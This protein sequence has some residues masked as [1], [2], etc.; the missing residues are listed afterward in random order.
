MRREQPRY[1]WV[2]LRP[3]DARI[4]A[5]RAPDPAGN[6]VG[7]RKDRPRPPG[8]GAPVSPARRGAAL[9]DGGRGPARGPRRAGRC[10]ARA[11]HDARVR[12]GLGARTPG[13][14]CLPLP[15]VACAARPAGLLRGTFLR[16]RGRPLARDTTGL[17]ACRTRPR[18][19][20]LTISGSRHRRQGDLELTIFNNGCSSISPPLPGRSRPCRAPTRSL[21]RV[22][23]LSLTHTHLVANEAAIVLTAPPRRPVLLPPAARNWFRRRLKRFNHRQVTGTICSDGSGN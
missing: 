8:A 10:R 14:G 20:L 13:E 1:G 4:S 12:G 7:A 18:M 9:G 11:E 23:D 2:S 16:A 22:Q 17:L 5:P 6:E 19:K 21:P 15:P 3:D